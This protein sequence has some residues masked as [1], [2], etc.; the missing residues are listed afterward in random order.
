[1]V[2]IVELFHLTQLVE[3]G[4]DTV[5][6]SY[7]DLYVAADLFNYSALFNFLDSCHYASDFA[8]VFNFLF[9]GEWREKRNDLC[10]NRSS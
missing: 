2:L 10:L 1:M 4:E 5:T 7:R 9:S 8:I 3:K 6:E